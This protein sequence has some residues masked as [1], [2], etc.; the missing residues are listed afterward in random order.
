MTATLQRLVTVRSQLAAQLEDYYHALIDRLDRTPWHRQGRRIK[1]SEVEVPA[2]VLK[3]QTR[4]EREDEE[5]RRRR[6]RDDGIDPTVAALYE[7]PTRRERREEVA[8]PDERGRVRRAVVLGAPGGGKSF[9]TEITAIDLARDGLRR[10]RERRTPAEALPLPVHLELPALAQAGLPADLA[11]AALE[12]LRQQ[13]SL[14]EI[15]LGWLK[16]GLRS[17]RCWLVLDALDQV[18]ERDRKALTARLKQLEQPGWAGR[19][20]LTCRTANYDRARV[21]WAEL[22]EYELAPFRPED[23]RRL[24]ERWFGAGEGRGRALADLLQR[25]FALGHACRNPL[26]ATLT[27]LAHEDRGVTA[28]TT[29]GDLYARVLRGLARRAW[30]E[31]PLDPQDPHIDDLLRLLEA[32]APT[33]FQAHPESNQFT[34]REVLDALGA[35]PDRPLPLKLRQQLDG[36][37]LHPSVLAHTPTLLRDELRAC[38]ILVG[39]GLNRGGEQTYSFLHRSFL[40]YLTAVSLARRAERD[41]WPSIA[42]LI[43]RKAWSAHWYEVVVLL[44]G[45]LSDPSPLLELLGDA[46]KD[47]VFRHRLALAAQGLAEIYEGRRTLCQSG[48]DRIT[49]QA[50]LAWWEHRRQQT[51]AAVEH[52]YEALPALAQVNGRVQ[53]TTLL[54]WISQR[55][56]DPDDGVRSAAAQAVGGM[57]SVAAT[58]EFLARLAELLRDPNDDVRS[59]A[60]WAVGGVGGAAATPEFLARLAELLRDPNKYVRSAAAW[61][62]EGVGGAAAGALSRGATAVAVGPGASADR[63]R[64]RLAG[65][66]LSHAHPQR[67]RDLAHGAPVRPALAG[68]HHRDGRLADA[69]PPGQLRLRQLPLGQ[70]PGEIGCENALLL[71][72]PLAQRL[73]LGGEALFLAQDTAGLA[74][75]A[76]EP[77]SRLDGCLRLPPYRFW[78]AR[79]GGRSHPLPNGFLSVLIQAEEGLENRTHP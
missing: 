46:T 60:A 25:S 52:L 35:V 75:S 65:P 43:D 37:V 74:A 27:C 14:P 17:V 72:Q 68:E 29:R 19:V 44:A 79:A 66:Q 48:I 15:L 30:H 33:L 4:R 38:G 3:Q 64:A 8:W 10:L 34:N 21:P 45:R 36:G 22:T 59:A 58:P 67:G 18:E 40:E 51:S 62:V 56:H 13:H 28:E 7:E 50:F 42:G 31:A 47:D 11:D 49:E 57:G 69:D 78:G 5:D 16:E 24:V 70:Q 20:L 73:V 23:T 39:A 76:S 54:D 71:I 55:L 26:L 53:E 9:L 1:A 32:F 12:L 6:R 41:G 63:V 77:Q 2:R 61:A